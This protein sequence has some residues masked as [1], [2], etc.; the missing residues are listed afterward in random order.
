MLRIQKWTGIYTLLKKR[1]AIISCDCLAFKSI[2]RASTIKVNRSQPIISRIPTLHHQ[3]CTVY[4]SWNKPLLQ[5]NWPIKINKIKWLSAVY[6]GNCSNYSAYD[7]FSWYY[8][9]RFKGEKYPRIKNYVQYGAQ[10]AM[11]KIYSPPH[12][13][14][15]MTWPCG[16]LAHFFKKLRTE[17]SDLL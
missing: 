9:Y 4:S 11:C 16:T 13:Q 8:H 14:N 6:K 15:I 3:W 2:V 12:P 7:T 17:T 10:R 1:N 5:Y